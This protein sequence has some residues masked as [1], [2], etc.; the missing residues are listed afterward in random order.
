MSALIFAVDGRSLPFIPVTEAAL[1]AIHSGVP[2]K[3]L[4]YARSL[5]VAVLELVNEDR[6]SRASLSRKQLGARAGVSAD[7]VSDL[8]PLLEEAGVLQVNER[9]V[10][11]QRVEN[12]WVVIEPGQQRCTPEVPTPVARS[13]DPRGPEPQLPQESEARGGGRERARA[14]AGRMAQITQGLTEELPTEVAGDAVM[15]L[16]QKRKVNG[17]LV[18]PEEMQIAAVCV[19]EFNA[20]SGYSYGLGANIT[21]VVMRIREY[22]SWPVEKHRRLVRSAFR[23]KWWERSGNTRRP[24]P[25][26]IWGNERCFQN[27]VQDAVEEARGDKTDEGSRFKPQNPE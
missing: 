22:P 7:L 8:A 2:A 24:T 21:G 11:D 17:H 13:Q 27:V 9:W 23:F 12:E 5:Y 19:A 15:L 16:A 14:D 18:T 25:N 6:A 20:L 26:V 1:K 3:R 4:V 10:G